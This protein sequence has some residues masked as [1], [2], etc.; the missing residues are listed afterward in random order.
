MAKLKC[1]F[2]QEVPE[3]GRFVNAGDIVDVEDE[4]LVTQLTSVPRVINRITWVEAEAARHR[5]LQ[6]PPKPEPEAKAAPAKPEPA[7]EAPIPQEPTPEAEA[8]VKK[9]KK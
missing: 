7:E 2:P 9:G 8:P 5:G 6:A 3:L 4:A 1:L